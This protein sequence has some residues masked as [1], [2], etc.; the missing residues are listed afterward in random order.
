MS[1]LILAFFAL[2]GLLAA[3]HGPAFAADLA[4][5]GYDEGVCAEGRYLNKIRDRFAYQVKHVPNLPD[6]AI[7][8]FYS[9]HERRYLPESEEWPIARRYCQATVQL[10]DGRTR[11]VW[12]LIEGRMGFASIGENVEF[13]VSGFDRWLVYNGRCRVLR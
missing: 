10:S 11:D 4:V 6:V 7:Q 3:G 8:E 5:R 12:Y 1:R 13:C 2:L 9:I